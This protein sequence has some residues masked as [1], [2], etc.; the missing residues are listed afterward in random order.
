MVQVVELLPSKYKALSSN[1]STTKRT[2]QNKTKKTGY[3]DFLINNY[4]GGH[5]YIEKLK[6]YSLNDC[7]LPYVVF[8]YISYPCSLASQ[9]T[10]T[11]QV[12]QRAQSWCWTL[13]G[14]HGIQKASALRV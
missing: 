11:R 12:P 1:P 10:W 8:L 14:V 3:V 9:A 5:I 13:Q 6:N 7:S 4:I 2:K